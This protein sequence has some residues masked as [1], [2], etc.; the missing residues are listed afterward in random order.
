[1]CSDVS[2]FYSEDSPAVPIIPDS[3]AEDNTG[4]DSNGNEFRFSGIHCPTCG[5]AADQRF[6]GVRG[7]RTHRFQHG[8]ECRI[9][10]CKQCGLYFA[11]PFPFPTNAQRLYGDPDKYFEHHDLT[12]KIRN[13]RRLLG[14]FRKRLGRNDLSILDVGSGR[15][16]LLAAAKAEGFRMVV[17]MELSQAMIDYAKAHF[18]A[19]VFG[20]TIEQFAVHTRERFDV[21]VLNA[22][23]EHVYDPDSMIAACANLLTPHGLL[24]LDIPNEDHLLARVGALVNR[25]SNRPDVFVLSPT[26]PPFHVF[27]FSKRSIGVL[28]KKHGFVIDRLRVHARVKS[29]STQRGVTGYVLSLAEISL[30]FIA[31]MTG[32]ASNMYI[33]ARRADA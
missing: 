6:V 32:T 15:G 13:F 4:S 1:M 30:H 26:F 14:G 31:N 20:G 27:G 3:T 22:V 10:Q 2:E 29:R 11:N 5:P 18:D 9:Q 12:N 25:L 24:Y 28:L 23:L 7:G 19:D 8:V 21:I 17:G 33:W 16:E